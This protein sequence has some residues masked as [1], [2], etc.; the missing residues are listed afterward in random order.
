MYHITPEIAGTFRDLYYSYERPLLILKDEKVPKKVLDECELAFEL[1]VIT[2]G[3]SIRKYRVIHRQDFFQRMQEV[4]DAHN[5]ELIIG[6]L[7]TAKVTRYQLQLIC[8]ERTSQD[9]K[10]PDHPSYLQFIQKFSKLP[11]RIPGT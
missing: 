3:W 9:K 1:A 4:A 7:S 10:F 2:A 8:P 6:G 5:R 11:H